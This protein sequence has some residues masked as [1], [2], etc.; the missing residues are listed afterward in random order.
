MVEVAMEWQW[1][2]C[3]YNLIVRLCLMLQ[4]TYYAKKYAGIINTGLHSVV[5]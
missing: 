1:G 3:I 2:E 5:T 4:H